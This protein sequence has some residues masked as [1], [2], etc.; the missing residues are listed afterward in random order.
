MLPR[1][2]GWRV[3]PGIVF[4][5]RSLTGRLMMTTRSARP[6]PSRRWHAI[7]ASVVSLRAFCVC[8]VRRCFC[9]LFGAD[10]H[11]SCVQLEEKK[12][13][14]AL[15]QG[16]Q[17]FALLKMKAREH[18]R[19]MAARHASSKVRAASKLIVDEYYCPLC[20]KLRRSSHSSYL[21]VSEGLSVYQLLTTKNRLPG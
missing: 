7:I 8:V 4:R 13:D 2:S 3:R 17:N 1:G 12:E 11:A 9:R 19:M 5:R 16:G 21:S 6:E 10:L 20:S 14:T 18:S 15:P